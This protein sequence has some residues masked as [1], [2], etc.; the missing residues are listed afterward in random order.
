MRRNKFNVAPKEERTWR[1][2]TYASKAEMMYAQLLD[3]LL[4]DG[5]LV[6][7]REQPRFHLGCPENIYVADFLVI[8]AKGLPHVVDVK[9]METAKFKRDKKLWKVYGDMQLVIV[10]QRGTRFYMVDEIAG[11]KAKEMETHD[12]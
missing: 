3:L 4:K 9:G 10:K 12:E 8:P 2:R 7:V 6:E 5:T 11:G 1:D